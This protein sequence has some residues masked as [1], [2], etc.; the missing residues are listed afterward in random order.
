M[1]GG[2]AILKPSSS[3]GQEGGVV[4]GRGGAL[5]GDPEREFLSG[6]HLH[7]TTSGVSR[8]WQTTHRKEAGFRP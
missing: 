3:P 5:L 8:G 7:I 2:E 4:I 1:L 6:C